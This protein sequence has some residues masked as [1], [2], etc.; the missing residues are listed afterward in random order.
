MTMSWNGWYFRPKVGFVAYVPPGSVRNGE[1][2]VKTGANGKTIA[3]VICHGEDLRGL[4]TIPGIAGRSPAEMA[5]QIY[6]LRSGTRHGLN[7][8]L[9]M[10]PISKLTDT[11]IVNITA[12]LASLPQ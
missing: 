9:M 12:Y 8:P 10:I 3:C 6:D 2:I 1:V 7:A 5:R 11:D 4:G